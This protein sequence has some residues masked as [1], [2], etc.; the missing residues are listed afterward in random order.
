MWVLG[1]TGGIGSGKTT[2]SDL[3]AAH[4]IQVVDADVVARQSLDKGSPALEAVEARYG[5]Q[6]LQQDGSLNR[7]WLR[8]KIFAEP[9]EKQWLNALTHPLIRKE[10]LKQ[11]HAATS[12]YV[13]LSAPLLLE[14]K[15]TQFCD[16]V[17]VVDVTEA[18]QR[19]RTQ[20]RDQV[21]AAQVEQIIA[22][23]AS[24]AERLA[25]AD[26]VIDNNGAVS[27]LPAQVEKLHQQY[28]QRVAGSSKS[29]E[30]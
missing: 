15:L 10:M 11:L 4:G 9:E 21:S 17:L 13:I 23:Q 2:V 7:A 19:Q 5:S 1:L 25:A 27:Q 22:A 20:A 28:L 3:F 18:T 8:E 29:L 6:A 16:R 14:N 24:R 30:T 26:D 12:A